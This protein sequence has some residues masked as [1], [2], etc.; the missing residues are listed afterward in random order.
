MRLILIAYIIVNLGC[1]KFSLESIRSNYPDLT[2]SHGL[3]GTSGAVYNVDYNTQ[4]IYLLDLYADTAQ[5]SRNRYLILSKV[6][7]HDIDGKPIVEIIDFKR[8]QKYN[9]KDIRFAFCWDLDGKYNF[10]PAIY[11]EKQLALANPEYFYP[12]RAYGVDIDRGKIKVLKKI[13]I[14]CENIGHGI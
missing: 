5:N 11:I 13:N 1:S 8:L 6:L 7:S 9:S 2:A 10:I 14:K 12:T 3:I 4:P